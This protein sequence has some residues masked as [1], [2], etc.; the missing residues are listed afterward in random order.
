MAL[1]F[2]Q[3]KLNT[4]T[5][6]GVNTVYT[7]NVVSGNLLTAIMCVQGS[8]ATLT[9]MGISDTIGNTWIPV[10]GS[11][12]T[13]AGGSINKFI[14]AWYCLTKASGANTVAFTSNATGTIGANSGAIGEFSGFSGFA[15]LDQKLAVAASGGTTFAQLAFGT[16][17]I[18]NEIFF[19]WSNCNG[20]LSGTP[21]VNSPF[22]AVTS[23]ASN[24]IAIDS[25]PTTIG[26]FTMSGTWP[27]P[28]G[29]N[30]NISAGFSISP[31][32]LG[33]NGLM[34]VGCG[35]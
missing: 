34:L 33:T 9:T 11:I 25:L 12:Q 17:K 24:S 5:T 27:S 21:T 26:A 16:T 28:G 23:S 6:S 4:S 8:T 35:T 15:L 22:A 13:P 1:A 19:C 32:P 20:A 10:F 30:T 3:A 18:A 14:Q 7:S 29:A 31:T 2:V